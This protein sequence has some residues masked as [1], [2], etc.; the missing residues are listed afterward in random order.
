MIQ[1]KMENEESISMPNGR[2]SRVEKLSRQILDHLQK[3]PEASDTLEG[4]AAWWLEQ[5][6]IEQLVEEVADALE[7]LV[8]KGA[9]RAHKKN[10]GITNY[11]IK[12]E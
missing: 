8:K 1:R 4:I 11:K 9:V 2:P 10:D 6:Q 5:Q 12:K 7:L 3:H